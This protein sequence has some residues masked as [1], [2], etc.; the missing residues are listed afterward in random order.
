MLMVQDRV[1][2]KTAHVPEIWDA[3][4]NLFL[5]LIIRPPIQDHIILA[6][7]NQ[8]Q[9]ERD[10]YAINRS[11]VKG[12]VDVLLHLYDESIGI[13][14]YKRDLEPAFLRESEAFYKKEGEYLLE[15]CDAP[16][17]LRRVSAGMKSTHRR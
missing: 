14:V 8:I 16:E 9:T 10:G 15:T 7:L 2:S 17:Y 11:A 4:L 5:Q 6:I 13:S 1:Y 12:C 3:G